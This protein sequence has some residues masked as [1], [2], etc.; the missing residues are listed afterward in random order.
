MPAITLALGWRAAFLIT[1]GFTVV[2]LVVWLWYYRRPRQHAH[3]AAAE[4]AHI[5]SDP[6]QA[7]HA[8]IPWL[9]LCRYRQTWA[10]IC[11][12]FLIDPIWWTFLFWL[13]DFFGKRYGLDLKSYGPPLVAIY[14]F[15]DIGSIFGGLASSTLLQRG[16]SLNL[17]R[18]TAMLICAIAVVP[19]AFAA[20]AGNLWIAVALIGLACA[21]HQGFSA[22]LYALP[23]DLFPRWAAGSVIGLGG[24]SGALGGML[25]AKYAGWVLESVGSYRP[26]FAVAAFAYV[27]A[28]AV[29]HFLVPAY[30]PA[31]GN[32]PDARGS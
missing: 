14:V 1:G 24:A 15:A 26:I 30:T 25:M 11:G 10:Y 21:G 29:V 27:L 22:N 5:E 8:A 19:V 16:L 28:L 12:R 13:P 2:W 20:N 23:S 31:I 32:V 7:P 3:V 4:L 6:P 17:S 18:K 9:R